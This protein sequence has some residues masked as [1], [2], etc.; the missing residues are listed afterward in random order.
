MMTGLMGMTL[1]VPH[2]EVSVQN[3][4]NLSY[5]EEGHMHIRMLPSGYLALAWSS[6][7]ASYQA[8]WCNPIWE[9]AEWSLA[10]EN[11]QIV[12]RMSATLQQ[13]PQFNASDLELSDELMA[14]GAMPLIVGVRMHR[15]ARHVAMLFSRVAELIYKILS[16]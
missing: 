5:Y 15:W 2:I 12:Q 10:S 7:T 16:F 3:L 6:T 4:V 8:M 1:S 13:L 9:L 11:D 14:T